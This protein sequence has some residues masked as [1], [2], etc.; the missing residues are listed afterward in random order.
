MVADSD[1]LDFFARQRTVLPGCEGVVEH[2]RTHAFAVQA[3]DLV[4]EM[5]EHA[6][7]LVITTFDDAQ[8]GLARPQQLQF[9]G[10]G[11]EVFEGEV[12]ALGERLGVVD[13]LPIS[14]S[15]ST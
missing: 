1:L 10:L 4:V 8:P 7:D 15:V 9:G 2:Q 14:C 13:A 5:A 3:H 11:G 12:Q 6:F